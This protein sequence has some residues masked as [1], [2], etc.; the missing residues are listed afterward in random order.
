[1]REDRNSQF[2]T[3]ESLINQIRICYGGRCSESIKFGNNKITT[4]AS[5]DIQQATELI[6]KYTALY[7]FD[8]KLSLLNY[9]ALALSGIID[10]EPIQATMQDI[11]KTQF[12][13]TKDL[14]ENNYELVEALV[15]S[16]LEQ[17]TMQGTEV[18]ALLDSITTKGG[19]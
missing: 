12:D 4:G 10:Q 1:M 14:L 6:F 13:K 11:A 17:E 19:T 16:I 15:K 9:Q 5:N 18:V 2:D 8:D 7:G 3:Q